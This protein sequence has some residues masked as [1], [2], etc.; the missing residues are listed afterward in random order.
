MSWWAWLSGSTPGVRCDNGGLAGSYLLKI[1]SLA[2]M[3]TL[4]ELSSLEA[5][6]RRF[7]RPKGHEEKELFKNLHD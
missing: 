3:A 1:G 2:V 6:R 5:Y 7:I 4:N